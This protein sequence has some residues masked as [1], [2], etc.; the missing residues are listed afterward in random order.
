M[1]LDRYRTSANE[2]LLEFSF[3]S[4]GP[5]GEI[6]KVIRFTHVVGNLYNLAFG[7]LDETTGNMEDSV[8]TNNG[9]GSKVLNTV[10]ASI[11]DFINK[12]PNALIHIR[13]STH[14]RTRLYRRAITFYWDA[15]SDRFA[16]YGQKVNGWEE[17]SFGEDYTAFLIHRINS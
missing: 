1:Y 4:V 12:Y 13:G 7:D 6:K 5:K 17:F 16:V 10:A 11:R 2:D 8:T 14:S 9:D 15:I 3:F